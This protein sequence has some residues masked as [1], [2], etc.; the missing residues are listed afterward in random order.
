M[1]EDEEFTEASPRGRSWNAAKFAALKTKI[2]TK[3]ACREVSG[4]PSVSCNVYLIDRNTGNGDFVAI[5]VTVFKWKN[6]R[7]EITR[8]F[9]LNRLVLKLAA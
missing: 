3:Y 1:V 6:R 9:G 8:A 2:A 7:T 5:A 4:S